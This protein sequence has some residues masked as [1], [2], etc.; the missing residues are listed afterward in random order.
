[1]KTLRLN[2]FL[3]T[4]LTAI[5]LFVVLIPYSLFLGWNLGTGVLFWFILVPIV[6]NLSS[7]FFRS[8]DNLV[9]AISGELLFYAFMVF[10]TYKHYESDL[11]ILM[12]YSVL[13]TLFLLVLYNIRQV[14]FFQ[15]KKTNP[16]H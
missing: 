12:V 10:M 14:P 7:S 8:P 1:M 5:S 9:A 6:A 4:F 2:L 13:P 15:K 16:L 11:F 3:V